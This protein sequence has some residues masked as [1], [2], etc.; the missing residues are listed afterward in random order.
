MIDDFLFI[1]YL[2]LMYVLCACC[3]FVKDGIHLNG[4]IPFD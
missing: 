2:C 3:N 1:Y 4:Y